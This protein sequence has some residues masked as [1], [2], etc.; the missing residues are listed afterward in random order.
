M[1]D[2]FQTIES[3]KVHQGMIQKAFFFILIVLNYSGDDLNCPFLSNRII[4]I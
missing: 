1:W 3:V 4:Q 2:T